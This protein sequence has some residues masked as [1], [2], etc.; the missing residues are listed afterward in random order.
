SRVFDY[1]YPERIAF[2]GE[3]AKLVQ[4]DHLQA[5]RGKITIHGPARFVPGVANSTDLRGSMA[6][7][8]AALCAE[9]ESKILNVQM[10]LRG[11]NDLQGKLTRL[12]SR[13]T[14]LD[15]EPA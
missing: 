8:I 14:V 2:V 12:G 11:Y 4:G 1:R 6:A 10:A 15:G 3:L 7:V 13:I 5:E 9:G